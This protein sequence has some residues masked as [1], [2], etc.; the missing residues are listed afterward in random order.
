MAS[1]TKDGIKEV[2]TSRFNDLWGQFLD[3]M[4]MAFPT[5]AQELNTMKVN[6]S[7]LLSF[8]PSILICGF[9]EATSGL[10]DL[11]TDKGFCPS[12]GDQTILLEFLASSDMFKNIGLAEIWAAADATTQKSMW[13]YMMALYNISAAY[14]QYAPSTTPTALTRSVSQEDLLAI[15]EDMKDQLSS[16]LE[17]K[18]VKDVL[19]SLGVDTN[20]SAADMQ[21]AILKSGQLQSMLAGVSDS[22]IDIQEQMNKLTSMWQEADSK[23]GAPDLVAIARSMGASDAM[24]DSVMVDGALRPELAEMLAK[25]VKGGEDAGPLAGFIKGVISKPSL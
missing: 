4:I 20:V 2:L 5:K 17:S 8:R 25:V 9:R 19:T 18:G 7:V 16:L 6:V 3:K 10:N 12:H 14:A 21:D 11:F 24:L 13:S 22:G 23:G 15:P 1:S